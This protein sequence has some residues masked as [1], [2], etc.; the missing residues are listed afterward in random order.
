MPLARMAS[1]IRL[2]LDSV[3][4]LEDQVEGLSRRMQ[5]VEEAQSRAGDGG[6]EE[7]RQVMWPDRLL[8]RKA[9]Y[10]M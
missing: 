4:E 5:A 9:P 2:L 6:A 10:W 3:A 8:W 7:R 1:Q